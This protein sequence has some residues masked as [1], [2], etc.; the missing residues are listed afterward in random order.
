MTDPNILSDD[1]STIS[2]KNAT[3]VYGMFMTPVGVKSLTNHQQHK[4]TI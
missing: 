2:D 4:A 1:L 3:T